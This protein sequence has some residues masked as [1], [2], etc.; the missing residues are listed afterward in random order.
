MPPEQDPQQTSERVEQLLAE[1]QSAGDPRV[2]E[3]AEEL[4]RALMQLYGAGLAKIIELAG[5]GPPGKAGALDVLLS[6]ELITSLLVMHDLHPVDVQDRVQR[7]L[8]TVRPYLGS[9]SGGVEFLGIGDDGVVHLRLQGNC[10]GCPSS[11]ATV[12]MAIERAIGEAAPEVTGLDVEGMTETAPDEVPTVE[13]NLI[14]VE[15]LLHGPNGAVGAHGAGTEPVGTP[16]WARV[17][18]VSA[19]EAGQARCLQVDGVRVLACRAD[20]ELYAYRDT[21]AACDSSLEGASLSG[22][23][24]SCPSCGTT[25]DVRLAGRETGGGDRH[26][27]PLP[28]LAEQG[29]VRIA[30]P[31]GAAR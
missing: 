16:E 6:D 23:E 4:V 25:F 12:K 7:A 2:R 27:E 19:L 28:L 14:P 11:T 9:H 26:L 29:D 20:G 1:I 30:V 21:C 3:R 24:L 15:S 5:T 10:E 18:E 13:P 31:A 8:D 17:E 22:T